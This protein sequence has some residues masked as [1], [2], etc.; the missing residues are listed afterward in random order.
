M[1]YQNITSTI[2]NLRAGS[3]AEAAKTYKSVESAI[4]DVLGAKLG[5]TESHYADQVIAGTYKTKHFEVCPGAQKFFSSLPK[6][7]NAAAIEKSAMLHDQL[8]ALEKQVVAT[9]SAD[10]HDVD[11]AI[12]LGNKISSLNTSLGAAPDYIEKHVELIRNHLGK[13]PNNPF[14]RVPQNG[15]HERGDRQDALNVA[16]VAARA[17][18]VERKIKIIDND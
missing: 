11:Q 10:K 7:A 15:G 1:N 16:T 18:G 12:M 5:S 13:E 14:N 8:F 3:V 17:A 4:R 6:H 2:R 9:Q